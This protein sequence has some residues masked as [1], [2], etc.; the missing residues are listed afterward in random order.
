MEEEVQSGPARGK[1]R[2]GRGTRGRGHGRCANRGR[3]IDD[4]K[5][6]AVGGGRGVAADR[7][8]HGHECGRGRGYGRGRVSN[9]DRQRLV[10]TFEDGDDY[11]ELA[12]LLGI[13]YKTARSIILI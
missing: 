6:A 11:H 10:D 2:G 7:G 5:D 13:P 9:V 4:L 1:G 12:A 8:G 3:G